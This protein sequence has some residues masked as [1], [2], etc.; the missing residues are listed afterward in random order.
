MCEFTIYAGQTALSAVLHSPEISG[1]KTV[2]VICHGF[3]GS[4]DGGGRAVRLADMAARLGLYVLRFDFTPC[5]TLTRQIEELNAVINYVRQHIGEQI[6]LLG[7]SM[8][9]SAALAYTASQPGNILGLC[10]W[11]APW[12]LAETFRLS[13]GKYYELLKQGESITLEDEYGRLTLYPEFIAD[14]NNYDLRASVHAL[15]HIPLLQVHGTADEV[16]P[17]GQAIELHNVAAGPKKLILIE[18]GDHQLHSYFA[19][20]STAVLDWLH[21]DILCQV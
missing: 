16:V 13:L 5:Q 10:L 19:E 12:N 9:G 7:R 11:A 14:F 8:G 15:Q 17:V 20:A 1:S 6:I 3:R 2:F 21:D 18:G 4:K